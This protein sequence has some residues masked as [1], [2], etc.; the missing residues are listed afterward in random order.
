MPSRRSNIADRLRGA[1]LGTLLAGCLDGFFTMQ[2]LVAFAAADRWIRVAGP[3]TVNLLARAEAWRQLGCDDRARADVEMLLARDFSHS[4]ANRWLAK[5]GCGERRLAAA[6]TLNGLSPA[7]APLGLH[8]L[9]D[10]GV[11]GVGHLQV[12]G[13]LLSGWVA[14]RPEAKV[15][16]LEF[17]QEQQRQEIEPDP[18]H[19][20]HGY[21]GAAAQ[22]SSKCPFD[23]PFR[24][25]LLVN[26][27]EVAAARASSADVGAL[28]SLEQPLDQKEPQPSVTI[29]IPVYDDFDATRASVLAAAEALGAIPDG[30]MVIVDDDSPNANLKSFLSDFSRQSRRRLLVNPVNLGFVGAVN[31]GLREI[32]TGDV[33]L[34]NADT[35][36]PKGAVERFKRAVCDTTGAGVVNP[37]SNHGEFVSFP[38]PFV[39]NDFDPARWRAI[40]AAAAASGG[41]CVD[42]PSGTGFCMYITRAC[43]N[44]VDSLCKQFSAGYLEDADFGLRA[45]DAGFRNICCPS[46]Y[47]PH[48]GS[49][50]FKSKKYAL[51]ARNRLAL[52]RRF[53]FYE[54]ECDAFVQSDP[55]RPARVRLERALVN[56][57]SA[58]R[59]IVGPERCVPVMRERAEKLALEKR[60]ALLALIE[61]CEGK[62]NIRMRASDVAVPQ[63]DFYECGNDS[64]AV[65]Q[66]L[67]FWPTDSIELIATPRLPTVLLEALANSPVPLDLLV[68]GAIPHGQV[69]A[70]FDATHAWRAVL[71]K[72]KKLIGLDPLGEAYCKARQETLALA[73]RQNAAPSFDAEVPLMA[74]IH[75]FETAASLKVLLAL[76]AEAHGR[77]FQI[78]VL[79]AT[80]CDERLI[81]SG[82]FVTGPAPCE[83]EWLAEAYRPHAYFLPYRDE[84]FWALDALKRS[85]PAPSAFFDWSD[86]AFSAGQADLPLDRRGSDAEVA[87][88][89]TDWL[90]SGSK[91]QCRFASEAA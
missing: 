44:A 34:L 14:W 59:M 56:D 29:L 54:A 48:L 33:L 22:I 91:I 65:A 78:V 57:R 80:S 23:A 2:P 21:L 74:V 77:G 49:R 45:R 38:K 85:F 26:G 6:R 37:L 89:L 28:D 12:A 32:R 25:A 55:L 18:N 27:C 73:E 84:A 82:L 7:D 63:N 41:A 46:I 81:A 11:D 83:I 66:A 47:V 50:S 58:F 79:G 90:A 51:V 67:S 36:L 39:H 75:P 3:N 61:G 62:F 71:A 19:P 53:P 43:L 17:G 88:R 86:G 60:P 20:W 24:V 68:A 70:P 9:A 35:L 15:E 64:E 1:T 52:A 4:G 69:N 16:L 40:D 13:G 87:R 10:A 5:W 42:I 76:A 31:R 8:V 72:A 30:E